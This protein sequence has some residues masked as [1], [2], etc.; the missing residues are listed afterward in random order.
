MPQGT[1]LSVILFALGFN[2][3]VSNILLPIDDLAILISWAKLVHMKRHLQLTIDK[4][5]VLCNEQSFQFSAKKTKDLCYL[6]RRGYFFPIVN[7]YC[8]P[9]STDPHW[10][11]M[12]LIFVDRLSYF[13]RIH[14]LKTGFHR[15]FS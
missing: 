9:I 10:R 3:V 5:T 12:D 4:L 8:S 1:L 7:L 2:D 11:Y 14:Y 6:Q 13:R 15:L